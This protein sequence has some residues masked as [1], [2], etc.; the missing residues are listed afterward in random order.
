MHQR[1]PKVSLATQGLK[2]ALEILD[3]LATKG[4]MVSRESGEN[5]DALEMPSRASRVNSETLVC[6]GHLVLM[7]DQAIQDPMACLD[8]QVPKV[9]LVSLE[10]RVSPVKGE[11]Q[12]RLDCLGNQVPR[13]TLEIQGS[14][15]LMV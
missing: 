5:Q 3:H 11:V 6:L 14:L 9:T 12:G 13:V 10:S 2:V 15:D 8:F 4:W 7:E 1:G